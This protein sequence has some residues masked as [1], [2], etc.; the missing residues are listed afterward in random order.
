MKS[1]SLT[2]ATFAA[3]AAAIDPIPFL[4]VV[5]ITNTCNE[6]YDCTVESLSYLEGTGRP[7]F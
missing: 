6:D 5:D 7:Q 3:T 2:V 4:N 1:F